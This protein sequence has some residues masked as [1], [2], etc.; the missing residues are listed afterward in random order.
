MA[1]SKVPCLPLEERITIEAS[2]AST[3]QHQLTVCLD[4]VAVVTVDNSLR[5]QYP[6]PGRPMFGDYR[7]WMAQTVEEATPWLKLWFV[8][9]HMR[10]TS[11]PAPELLFGHRYDGSLAEQLRLE[12]AKL[13]PFAG[14]SDAIIKMARGLLPKAESEMAVPERQPVRERG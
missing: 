11:E 9:R 8:Q 1:D 2:S 4:G 6:R 5:G 14:N 13:N 10:F 12:Q 3:T 7:D